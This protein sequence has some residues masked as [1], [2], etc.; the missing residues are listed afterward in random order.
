MDGE[1]H[2]PYFPNRYFRRQ[3]AGK[4]RA[5]SLVILLFVEVWSLEVLLDVSLCF[6]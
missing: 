5:W 3:A 2:L 6:D 4:S 1:R